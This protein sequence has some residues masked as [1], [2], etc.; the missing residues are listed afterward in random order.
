MSADKQSNLPL[1]KL[2]QT[3]RMKGRAPL[4]TTLLNVLDRLEAGERDEDAVNL[5]AEHGLP[6]MMLSAME[7]GLLQA[8]HWETWK[9]RML[10]V[11]AEMVLGTLETVNWPSEV[12]EWAAVIAVSNG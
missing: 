9:A 3:E 8:P 1:G 12:R 7:M 5:L 6:A 11:D 2:V 4:M 10:P